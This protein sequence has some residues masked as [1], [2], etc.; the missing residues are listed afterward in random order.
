[1]ITKKDFS[2]NYGKII[3]MKYLGIDY[4]EKRVGLAISDD[5]GQFSFSSLTRGEE[6]F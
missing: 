1:M 6:W 4:G 5:G 2:S 3:R